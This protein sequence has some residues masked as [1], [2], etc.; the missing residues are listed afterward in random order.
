MDESSAEV[1]V[2]DVGSA[3]GCAVSV[4]VDVVDVVGVVVVGVASIVSVSFFIDFSSVAGVD[5]GVVGVFG[6]DFC[7]ANIDFTVGWRGRPRGF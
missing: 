3:I 7:F 6:F 4:I 2:V 5:I 1:V